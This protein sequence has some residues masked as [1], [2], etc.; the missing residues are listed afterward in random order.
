MTLFLEPQDKILVLSP[1]A[2][3]EA[4]GCGG[5]LLKARNIGSKIHLVYVHIGN[6]THRFGK[7]KKQ[8]LGTTRMDEVKA[9]ARLLKATYEVYYNLPELEFAVD[10]ISRRELINRIEKT[11][12]HFKPTQILIP[13]P[14]FNQDHEAIYK[15]GLAVSRPP[16]WPNGSIIKKVLIYNSHLIHWGNNSFQPNL[17]VDIAD[18][19]EEKDYLIKT[20]KSQLR[21]S[22]YL[23]EKYLNDYSRC[24]GQ[25]NSMEYAEGFEI[26][27]FII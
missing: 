13:S 26:K 11:I 20:Y 19:L 22:G 16:S 4:M 10:T 25:E 3:D 23:S 6:S 9:V 24:L 18:V 17:I 27:R 12:D 5:Y 2:D 15:A 8:V 14:S 21:T 7:N 1:H